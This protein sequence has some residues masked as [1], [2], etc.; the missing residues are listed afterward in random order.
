MSI[1]RARKVTKKV[2]YVPVLKLPPL[3]FDQFMALRDNIAINGVLV[4]IIVTVKLHFPRLN[5][6][7]L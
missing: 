2:R 1:Q 4:P 7:S 5:H 3:P 6:N